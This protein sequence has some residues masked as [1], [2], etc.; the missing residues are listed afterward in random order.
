MNGWLN[1][2][3]DGSVQC[4][5]CPVFDRLFQVISVAAAAVYRQ[6]SLF[7]ILIFCLI[8]AFYILYAVWKNIKGGVEDPM[9]QKSIKPVLINSLFV[10]ALLGLGVY[11]P[12]FVSTITFEPVAQMT[13]AYTQSMVNTNNETVN[14]KVT[15]Q[16]KEMDDTGFYRPELRNTIIMLMKTTITQLQSYI[17]LGIA[18]MDNAFSWV[19]LTGVG[20]LVKHILMFFM[21]L[22][23][24]YEFFKIFIKFC[25]YF[26]DII[27]AMTFFAF[28]FPLSIVMFAFKNSDA[29]DW[30][31][32]LGKELGTGQIKNI[33]NSIIA[34]SAAVLTYTVVMV[35]IAKFFSNSGTSTTELMQMITSG[36]IFAGALSDDNLAAMTLMGCV[37][38]VYVVN[39]LSDQVGEVTKM[40]MGVF[41]VKEEKSLNEGLANDALKVTENVVKTVKDVSKVVFGGEKKEDKKE[42]KKEEKK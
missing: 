36:Q 5:G 37:V 12:R 10:F 11:L 14:E 22:Y 30:I 38:M 20:T 29:P 19:A 31:K 8:L 6:F 1:G 35:I 32:S 39:F 13:L 41:D 28:F 40:V 16:P 7:C 2:L 3:V 17:K 27:V 42:E 34:L 26:V 23:L 24:V 4:W 21:G 9:Y 25:F 15:Y 33:I 18:V